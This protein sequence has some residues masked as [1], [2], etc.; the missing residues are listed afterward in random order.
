MKTA[1]Q[2]EQAKVQ[3]PT[4]DDGIGTSNG[5]INEEVE[6]AGTDS[7]EHEEAEP[8]NGQEEESSSALQE[9]L[10]EV[11]TQ[12][13]KLEEDFSK[14]RKRTDEQRRLWARR[15]TKSALEELPT[16]FDDLHRWLEAVPPAGKESSMPQTYQTFWE[17]AELVCQGLERVVQRIAPNTE[18]AGLSV[19]EIIAIEQAQ[20]KEAVEAYRAE[21]ES[22]EENEATEEAE[23]RVREAIADYRMLIERANGMVSS[24]EHEALKT[25]A[26]LEALGLGHL[27]EESAVENGTALE[28][29][30]RQ[31]KR[32]AA[33]YR[34]FT[35]GARIAREHAEAEA[36]AS[37]VDVLAPVLKAFRSALDSAQSHDASKPAEDAVTQLQDAM[38]EVFDAFQGALAKFEVTLMQTMGYP[39][40]VERHEAVGHAPASGMVAGTVIY[41]ARRG[42]MYGD[43]VLRYAQVIVAA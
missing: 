40:D 18:E 17:G 24:K 28:Q 9:D 33:A 41:E 35:R 39:F 1:T 5:A 14:F 10:A 34:A 8:A 30:Q 27:E 3:E 16:V 13:E 6:A 12:R 19:A 7:T 29:E 22:R 2:E 26:S 21:V 20:L 42:Y 15:A 11:R 38:E 43:Q 4:I 32:T 37:V 36:R 31:L 23:H 25:H